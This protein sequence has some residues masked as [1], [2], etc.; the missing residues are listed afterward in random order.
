MS[1]I[2]VLL[3]GSFACLLAGCT[4][5][6]I[7][8]LDSNPRVRSVPGEGDFRWEGERGWVQPRYGSWGATEQIRADAMKAFQDGAHADALEGFKALLE[9]LSAGDPTHTEILFL[10][11][12]CYYS[13]ND[14]EEAVKFFTRVYRSNNASPENTQV[15]HRRIF[16]IAMDFLHGKAACA[17]L[18]IRYNCPGEGVDL[19]VGDEGLITE[20][21]HLEFADD[22][23]MEIAKYYF[24]EKEYPEAV[25]LFERVV[26]D[27]CPNRSE[28]CELAEYQV[29][30]ATFKQVRGIDYDQDLLSRAEKKFRQYLQ[31]YPRGAQAEAA[32]EFQREISDMLAERYLRIAKYY[33]RESQPRSARIYLELVVF[34]YSSSAAAREAREMQSRL[35]D[36][37]ETAG[38]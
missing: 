11:A 19:L 3:A 8:R 30:L 15:S 23:V 25:P 33:L 6:T 38:S 2:R 17:T 14:Y 27:Y 26:R 18:G 36:V 29:A 20:Y 28:W 13:L 37:T 7:K 5:A 10:T 9:R 22:A 35:A 24:D 21:R 32:R 12:E 1:A 34:K 4:T 16:D 31:H